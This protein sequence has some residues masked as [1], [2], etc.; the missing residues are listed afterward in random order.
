LLP[1]SNQAS[2]RLVFSS[3]E[4]IPKKEVKNK[5]SKNKKK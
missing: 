4:S 5:P 2:P 1:K 3:E